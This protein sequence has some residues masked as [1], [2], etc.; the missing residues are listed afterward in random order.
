MPLDVARH[1]FQI[2][3]D[4]VPHRIESIQSEFRIPAARKLALVI[5]EAGHD[6]NQLVIEK[7][8]P[9]LGLAFGSDRDGF[10]A[11][12]IRHGCA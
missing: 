4:F 5:V 11:C 7:Y 1:T 10:E 2:V 9:R 12:S 3:K 8:Q 6:S